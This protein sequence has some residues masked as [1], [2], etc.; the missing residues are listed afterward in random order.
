M[1]QM[2]GDTDVLGALAKLSYRDR[3]PGQDLNLRPPAFNAITD[4]KGPVSR[5]DHGGCYEDRMKPKLL[6]L[7]NRGH[8]S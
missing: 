7:A 6:P 1:R 3:S 2:E 8:H 4:V 5:M